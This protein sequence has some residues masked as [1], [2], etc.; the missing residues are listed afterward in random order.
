MTRGPSWGAAW[1]SLSLLLTGCR[2]DA[3]PAGLAPRPPTTIS[4]LSTTSAPS[5]SAPATAPDTSST[6]PPAP[7]A[8][9]VVLEPD[10]LGVVAFGDP[11]DVVVTRL[12]EALGPPV[13]DRALG[14]CPTGEA[15]RLVQFAELGVI[16]AGKGEA[17]RFVAWDLGLASGAFPELRTAEGVGVGSTLAELRAAYPTG[18]VVV[19]DAAFG[20]RFEVHRPPGVVSGTLAGTGDGDTIVTLGAGEVTCGG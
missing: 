2:E 17:E 7:S 14:S 13:D 20:P 9:E 16:L 19:P 11:A 15:D 12:G 1:L 4:P 18:L 5:T 8:P 10:G 3:D 6:L